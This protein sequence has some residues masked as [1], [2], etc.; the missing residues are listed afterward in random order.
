VLVTIAQ[1]TQSDRGNNHLLLV[2][3]PSSNDW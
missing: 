3:V 1:G 2:S